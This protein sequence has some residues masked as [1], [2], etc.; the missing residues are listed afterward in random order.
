LCCGSGAAD[1]Y[2][3]ER[4]GSFVTGI[5]IN[6]SQIDRARTRARSTDRLRFVLADASVWNPDRLY[7][8]VFSLDSLTLVA[9]LPTL[10][11]TCRSA[12]RPGGVLAIADVVEGKDLSEEMRAFALSE[13]G[14]VALIGP[15]ELGAAIERAGFRNVAVDDLREEAVRA[16]TLIHQ[17]VHESAG[18]QD[19]PLQKIEEWR[20]LSERYLKAFA[21]GELGYARIVATAA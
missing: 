21:A 12:L 4:F 10:L 13:D 18:W 20:L 3:A 7:D 11:K 9:D 19:V 1:C 2:L 17:S 14:A 16:F 6:E 8:L 15:T 5:D